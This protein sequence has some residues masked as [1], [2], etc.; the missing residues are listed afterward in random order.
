MSEDR[1]MLITLNPWEYSWACH[2]GIERF[3]ANWGK[4]DAK[5]YDRA[6]MEDDRTAQQAA[7]IC[8][9]AVAKATNR[10]W[11]GHYWPASEH[12]KNRDMADV[13]TNIEVRRVRTG[14]SAAVRRKQLNQGLILFAAHLPDPEFRTV[15]VWG[16]L[17][18]E[19]AWALG[20]PATYDKENTR[21]IHRSELN[22]LPEL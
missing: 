11:S 17:D 5:H 4:Q 20:E 10:Y 3:T 16:W 7:C 21:L 2:V 14:Q 1:N 15:E 13:G 8:E 22:P 19:T 18:M 6:R 9:L 12:H